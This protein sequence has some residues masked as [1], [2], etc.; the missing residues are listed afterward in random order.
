MMPKRERAGARRI[1]EWG[2]VCAA[3]A[4]RIAICFMCG[5]PD[6]ETSS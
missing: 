5:Q 1:R 2:R 4:E 3:C 6:L